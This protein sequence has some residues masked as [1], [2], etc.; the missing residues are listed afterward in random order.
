MTL[1]LAYESR[2]TTRDIIIK[3]AD[4][5]A[6][7]VGGSD[8]IRAIIGREGETAQL[9]V[10]S[11][12]PTVAGSTFTKGGGAGGSHRLRLDAS[13]LEFNP[14]TYTLFIDL[15]DASDASEWKNVDRQV[16][17]LEGSEG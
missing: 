11:D 5:N 8:E 13:D 10:A 9:T 6:I 12:A 14:G 16:F 2:G 7:S 17:Q 4:G 15:F 3:D 1:I